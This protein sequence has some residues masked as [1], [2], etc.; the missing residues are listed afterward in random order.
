MGAFSKPRQ[1]EESLEFKILKTARDKGGFVTPSEIALEARVSPD[2][3]KECLEE[4][5]AKG[6]AEHRIKR[7]GL[8]VYAFPEFMREERESE[9]EDL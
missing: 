3:A 9:L 5:V 8:I 4:M 1:P 7:A 2:T 6:Y